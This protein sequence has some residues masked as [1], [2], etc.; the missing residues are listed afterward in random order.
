MSDILDINIT[1]KIIICILVIF[2]L[3]RKVIIYNYRIM[4]ASIRNKYILDELFNKDKKWNY[5]NISKQVIKTYNVVEKS[6]TDDDIGKAKDY[7]G[8]ELYEVFNS[9]LKWMRVD[10]K[11]NILKKIKLLSV[12]PVVVKNFDDD[13]K[14]FIWFYIKGSMIN[15][16]IDIKNK[17]R[18]S[19]SKKAKSF[20]EFWKFMKNEDNKWI[21]MEILPKDKIDMVMIED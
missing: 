17:E 1:Y 16:V 5:K 14:D 3:F 4:M 6:W 18:L 11:K 13:K 10:N 7:M 2:I 8:K 12:K 21:L 15:Y 20:G 9:R 19:G